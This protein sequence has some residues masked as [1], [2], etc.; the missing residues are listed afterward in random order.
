MNAM[1]RR[2]IRS[3]T[4]VCVWAIGGFSLG[5]TLTSKD[6]KYINVGVECGRLQ[7]MEYE[8]ECL[9]GWRVSPE[10]PNRL[11]DVTLGAKLLSTLSQ[12]F[13]AFRPI[14][15]SECPEYDVQQSTIISV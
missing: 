7:G 13:L 1:W 4:A 5:L 11:D 6:D 3:V 9:D 15:Q 12:R 10:D 2:K 8:S 14:C